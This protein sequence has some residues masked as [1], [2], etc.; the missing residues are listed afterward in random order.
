MFDSAVVSDVLNSFSNISSVKYE[1]VPYMSRRQ[2]TLSRLARE[3]TWVS[4]KDYIAVYACIMDESLYARRANTS[5][6]FLEV[7]M[8][9]IGG[10][11]DTLAQGGREEGGGGGKKKGRKA[12]KGGGL[13][14]RFKEMGEKVSVTPESIVGKGVCVGGRVSLKKAVVGDGVIMGEGVKVNGSVVMDGVKLEDGVNL[15]GCIISH[16]AVI[17]EGCVLKDCRV[18]AEVVVGGGEEAS[19]RDFTRGG[20]REEEEE[21]DQGFEF[22]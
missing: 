11:V 21:E 18:A 17:G 6:M 1:L 15:A 8:D 3:G 19:G 22:G 10:K 2:H 9:I 14:G 20:G 4:G 13:E 7:S 16:G 5:R 12:A